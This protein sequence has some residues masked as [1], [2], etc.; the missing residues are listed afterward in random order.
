MKMKNENL[1]YYIELICKKID[2][3][4]DAFLERIEALQQGDKDRAEFIEKMTL[5]PLGCQTKYLA[6]KVIKMCKRS[7]H[8]R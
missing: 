1:I 4:A 5:K 2:L 8:G 6:G 3:D 7:N